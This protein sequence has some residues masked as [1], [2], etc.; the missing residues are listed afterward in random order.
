MARKE[1]APYQPLYTPPYEVA[2][3][4]DGIQVGDPVKV[5]G[6]RGDFT[7]IRVHV[8]K[9][10]VSDIIVHGGTSGNTAMR[11]FYPHRVKKV[12]KKRKRGS[13]DE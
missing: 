12:A 11:A 5:Q 7:F 8:T 9:G 10:A 3:E 13:S 6:E 4:W 2:T 1:I